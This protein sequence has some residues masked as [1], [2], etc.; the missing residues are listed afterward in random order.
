MAL[1]ILLSLF[2]GYRGFFGKKDAGSSDAGGG[3]D[4]VQL[5]KTLQ[6]ILDNQSKSNAATH[7]DSATEH[8]DIDHSHDKPAPAGTSPEAAAEMAQ[9]KAAVAEGRKKAEA[10]QIKVKEAEEKAAAAIAAAGSGGAAAPADGMSEQEKEDFAAKIRDLEAR[11]AEYEIISEDIADLSRYR[12]ENDELRKE[13]DNVKSNQAAAPVAAAPAPAAPQAA[14][15]VAPPPVEAA[16]PAPAPEV[17]VA[18]VAPMEES[19]NADLID[20]ELMR[21][22]AAAVEGQQNK[23]LEKVVE[24]AGD[25]TTEAKD[26]GDDSTKLMS[27]FEN[28]VTK[29]S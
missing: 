5:E 1:I 21:E 28:F 29:K 7:A 8:A 24:K 15:P 23:T 13:L 4:A 11:L 6:R 22:F 27:E 25:G 9:L 17:P 3:L 14:A 18:E 16:P 20:D 12:E 19:P 2:V 26:I 10:L